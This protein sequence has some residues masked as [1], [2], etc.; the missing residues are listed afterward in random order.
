VNCSDFTHLNSRFL[1][2]LRTTYHQQIDQ[3]I[4]LY[5]AQICKNNSCKWVAKR[6]W[7]CINAKRQHS[8]TCCNCW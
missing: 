2:Q 8:D 6:L 1:G 4:N 3:S 5:F 7:G